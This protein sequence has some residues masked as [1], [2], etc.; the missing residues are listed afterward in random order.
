MPLYRLTVPGQ[1]EEVLEADRLAVEGQHQVLRGTRL[2]MNQPR[3]VVV[4]RVPLTVV[5]EHLGGDD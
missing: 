2:V 3:E 1:P 4:R 5:I